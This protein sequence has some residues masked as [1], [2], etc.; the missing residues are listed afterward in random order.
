MD[1]DSAHVSVGR[2]FDGFDRWFHVL[3][4]HSDSMDG[5]LNRFLPHN[6]LAIEVTHVRLSDL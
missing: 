4:S 2:Q 5:I 3:C 6:P 1:I